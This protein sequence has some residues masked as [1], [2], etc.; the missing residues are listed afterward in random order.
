MIN[1]P[2]IFDDSTLNGYLKEYKCI[3]QSMPYARVEEQGI[4]KGNIG[5]HQHAAG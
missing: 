5:W 2:L 1:T 3:L 4:D